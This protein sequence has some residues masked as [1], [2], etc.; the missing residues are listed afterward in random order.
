MGNERLRSCIAGSN[1]CISDVAVQVGVDPKTVERWITRGRTPHRGHRWAT[2][3][4]LG[5]DEAYL[6][7]EILSD[8]RTLSASQAEF[9]ELYPHRGAVP[10]ELWSS[11]LN[12]ARDAIDILVFAGLFLADTTPDLAETLTAKARSGMRVRLLFGQY[13]SQAVRI[14]G[15][16]EGIGHDLAARVRLT[17]NYLR[18]VIGVRGINIRQH[19]T[20]LYNSIFRFDNDLLANTHAF[21]APAAQSPVLHLRRVP[22]GR[23]F[24]HYQSSFE[25]VWNLSRDVT[26]QT[27]TVRS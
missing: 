10:R 13:D 5:T 17:M 18:P 11:L 12:H 21:G 22:G 26:E 14:R 7:P 19:G 1:L 23:L 25:R 27:A 9:V 3:A 20:T 16:E 15:K 2:A 8:R 4:L 24:D 6:W